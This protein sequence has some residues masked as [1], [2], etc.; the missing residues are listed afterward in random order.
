MDKMVKFNKP[1]IV[2]WN[3]TEQTSQLVDSRVP[4]DY[5]VVIATANN[6]TKYRGLRIE[7]KNLEPGKI[8]IVLVM[9]GA[10]GYVCGSLTTN[11]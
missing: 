6:I 5:N 7:M 11:L 10:L 8:T 3:T 4:Q 9:I 1:D 2:I